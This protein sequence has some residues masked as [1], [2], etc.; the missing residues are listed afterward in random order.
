MR[1]REGV[2]N[3]MVGRPVLSSKGSVREKEVRDR[4]VASRAGSFCGVRGRAVVHSG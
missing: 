1:E 4:K 3:E 2:L